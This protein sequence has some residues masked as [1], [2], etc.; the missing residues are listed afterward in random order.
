M[1]S[2]GETF[3]LALVEALACGLP[4]VTTHGTDIWP[5]LREAGALLA[6]RTAD[7]FAAALSELI[8]DPV[9]ARRRGRGGQQYVNRW[10]STDTLLD[11]YQRIYERAMTIVS[12]K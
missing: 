12:P 3:G 10:L 6:P 9:S 1:P 4:V 5:E 11:D 7:G 8:A 2:Y